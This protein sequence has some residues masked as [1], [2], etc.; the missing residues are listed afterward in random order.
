ML[1][2]RAACANEV[3]LFSLAFLLS[4]SNSKSLHCENCSLSL[5]NSTCFWVSSERN[6]LRNSPATRGLTSTA[7]GSALED[8]FST[9]ASLP[10]DRGRCGSGFEGFCFLVASSLRLANFCSRGVDTTAASVRQVH[11]IASRIEHVLR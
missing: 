1:A 2:F 3:G 6:L 10:L 11:V 5:W 9:F 8:D 7:D 4:S